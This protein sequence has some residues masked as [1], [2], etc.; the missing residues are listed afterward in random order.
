MAYGTDFNNFGEFWNETDTDILIREYPIGGVRR[1]AELLPNRSKVSIRTR[2]SKLGL[3]RPECD[4]GNGF[5]QALFDAM[6]EKNAAYFAGFFDGE[7]CIHI[8]NKHRL[9]ITVSNTNER[10]IEMFST[11]IGGTVKIRSRR[12]SK[13]RDITRWAVSGQ[14]AMMFL[15]KM[16][17]YL[18]VKR[19]EAELAISYQK[20]FV[21]TSRK[22]SPEMNA[23]RE[24]ARQQLSDLKGRLK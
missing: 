23:D 4:R 20:Q 1:V 9:S 19:E 2:A 13:Q 22:I 21:Y 8:D 15:E 14:R 5:D 6:T 24:S 18:V 7:G 10:V 12:N 16:L 3:K 17:P 11:I